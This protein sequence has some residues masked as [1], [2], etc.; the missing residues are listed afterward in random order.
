M[1]FDSPHPKLLIADSH[2]VTNVSSRDF[3]ADMIG[4]FVPI[5]VVRSVDEVLA[6]LT[7][8]TKEEVGVV[9]MFCS[10][11]EAQSEV[12]KQIVRLTYSCKTKCFIILI[13]HMDSIGIG[14]LYGT[15]PCGKPSRIEPLDRGSISTQ[16]AFEISMGLY[17][18]AN[19][20]L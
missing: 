5:E 18:K 2:S 6:K 7:S 13:E 8:D 15:Y 10:I 3:M 1:D 14:N 19:P 11:D 20:T 12:V 9:L 4:G 16:V 17:G